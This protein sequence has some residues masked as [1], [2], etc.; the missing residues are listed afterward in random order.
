MKISCEKFCY[1]VEPIIKQ[2]FHTCQHKKEALHCIRRYR[3]KKR[4]NIN[5]ITSC[6]VLAKVCVFDDYTKI[7]RFLFVRLFVATCYI[8]WYVPFCSMPHV[9]CCLRYCLRCTEHFP[10]FCWQVFLCV[11]RKMRNR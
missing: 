10:V 2:T 6:K 3:K 7:T 5:E 8:F 1:I 11:Q 4:R 9:A